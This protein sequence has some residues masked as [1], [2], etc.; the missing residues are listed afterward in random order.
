MVSISISYNGDLSCDAQHGPSAAICRTDAPADIG[1]K[2]SC[3]SPTDLLATALG[4]CIATT[5]DMVARKHDLSLRGLRV[6]VSKEMTAMPPRRIKRLATHVFMPIRQGEDPQ[7]I[8]QKTAHICPVARSLHAD[9]EIPI[10]F[11]WK[12]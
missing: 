10:T 3:F 7:G 9:T 12:E 11:H 1:G 8:L 6:E 2:A 4:T 5:L